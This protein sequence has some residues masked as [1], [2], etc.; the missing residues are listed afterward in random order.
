[1][2]PLKPRQLLALEATSQANRNSEP[3][4]ATNVEAALIR[5]ELS[6]TAGTVAYTPK[7][8]RRG[9][10]GSWEDVWS[11]AADLAADGVAWYWI[12]AGA[13][14]ED[15]EIT[16]AVQMPLP[17]TWRFQ[18]AATTADGSNNASTEAEADLYI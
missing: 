16:E 9:A 3:V 10:D 11:A 1:M 5:V 2:K 13:A 12:G 14:A 15:G 6:S 17:A 4:G 8:Q 18:L 7:I